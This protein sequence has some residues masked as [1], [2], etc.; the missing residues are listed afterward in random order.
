MSGMRL[1]TRLSLFIVLILAPLIAALTGQSVQSQRRQ[2]EEALTAKG[3]S[4]G[5]ML[6]LSAGP[7]IAFN[8]RQTARELFESVALDADFVGAGLFSSK[9][10]A[11]EVRGQ[12]APDQWQ[13]DKPAGVEALG[14][15]LRATVPVTSAEGPKG[16]LVIELSLG[17]AA[18]IGR[19][20]A[21]R[22]ALFGALALAVA[23]AAAF[24]VGRSLG[25]RILA[26]EQVASA[27][28]RCDFTST[29]HS[30]SGDE[31]GTMARSLGAA[32]G[33][34]RE[35]L[36]ATNTLAS[37]VSEASRA[38]ASVSE[39]FSQGARDQVSRLQ[40]CAGTIERFTSSVKQNAESARVATEL[41]H[42]SRDTAEEG[43]RI[44]EAAVREMEG[45]TA[46]SRRIA[47][48]SGTIDEI[49][50]QTNLLALNAAVEAARAGE[51][52][53]GFAVVASEVRSLAQRSAKA[54]REIRDLIQQSVQRIDEGSQ[55]VGLSGGALQ[56]IVG[57]VQR[58]H[59]LI[60]EIS[61][62]SREQAS[63]V[64][65]VHRSMGEMERVTSS[66]T[67]KSDELS[68][69]ARQLADQAGHLRGLL[70]EFRLG[71]AR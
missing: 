67:G 68:R 44:T 48:I 23:I 33:K 10:Q 36:L 52:G 9:G 45:L 29:L 56:K 38:L 64:D 63:G 49:A 11:L 39:G 4:F 43:R 16:T 20:A 25:R 37:E 69:T 28:A 3:L 41:A 59:E 47:D 26:V 35:T 1:Q 66:S 55:K 2:A 61:G 6:A 8:D 30:D 70:A 51:Q 21:L 24:V 12:L 18:Q 15:R 22:G 54:S 50:F 65:D 19:Q 57:S 5:R 71:E 17:R 27:V 42:A 60:G 46:S 13:A 32:L 53:R 7:A 58:F 14:G 40:D 34:V 62:A 31:L